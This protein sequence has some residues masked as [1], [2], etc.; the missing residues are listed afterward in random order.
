MVKKLN[1]LIRELQLSASNLRKYYLKRKSR[2][3]PYLASYISELD[4]IVMELMTLWERDI[5]VDAQ[6]VKFVEVLYKRMQE[7]DELK[8]YPKDAAVVDVDR[9]AILAL[10]EVLTGRKPRKK[11]VKKPVTRHLVVYK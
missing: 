2:P 1:D 5:P 7:R 9:M 8:D 10:T 6:L 4:L 3:D 11:K